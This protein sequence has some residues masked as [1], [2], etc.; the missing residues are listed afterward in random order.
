MVERIKSVDGTGRTILQRIVETKRREVVASK[1]SRP[2]AQLRAEIEELGPPRDFH[3]A[4]TSAPE[5]GIALIAEIKKSSPSAGLIRAEFHPVEIAEAYAAGG[6]TALSVLTDETYF[7]GSL[8]FIREVK[9]VVSLP[10]LRKDFLVDEYQLYE[11]RAAGADAILLI[12]EVLGQEAIVAFTTLARHLSLGLLVEVHSEENLEAVLRLLGTPEEGAYLLGINN[13]DLGR[14][15]TELGTMVRLA[16]LLPS[17]TAFVAE[18]GI[19]S[20]K[21]VLQAASVGAHAVLVG[22]SLLRSDDLAAA[23]RE[24]LGD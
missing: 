2:L 21:D 11:S 1:Q 7:Q 22:E 12:M 23:V 9:E 8:K 6:A 20:R 16:K 14:Q 13:R 15:E 5:G 4:V 10:V 24:L 17:G 3:E 18:S 19:T